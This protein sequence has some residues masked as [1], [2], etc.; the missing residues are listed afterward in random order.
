MKEQSKLFIVTENG[1]LVPRYVRCYDN[2]GKT[3]DRYT[4]VFTGRN[5]GGMYLGMS[6]TP[7]HPQGFAQHG[8]ARNKWDRIDYPKSAHLGKRVSWLML[9][10]ECR[11]VAW[12]DY[13]ELNDCH[14][15]PAASGEDCN[16]FHVKR[17]DIILAT[18]RA[19]WAAK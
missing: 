12:G 6:A 5:A 17:G 19:R 3:V 11:A 4:V 1:A 14:V 7:T 2:G 18:V 15:S 9:P 16:L 8:E 13:E 10:P